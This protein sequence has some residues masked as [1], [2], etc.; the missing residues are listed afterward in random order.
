MAAGCARRGGDD[1]SR[2]LRLALKTAP[3]NLDPALVVDAAG[4]EICAQLFQGLVRYTPDGV[5]TG[6]AASA[7]HVEDD[8]RRYVF[9]LD[10]AARFSDG[11]RVTARDVVASFERVLAPGSA[12]SRRWVLDRIAGAGDFAAGNNDHIAG[13][14]A[15]DDSTVVLELT[16]PFA[17]FL[18][19]LALPA[20]MIVEAAAGAAGSDVTTPAPVGSGPWMVGEFRRGDVIALVPNPHSPRASRTL[21]RVR[22]RVIPEAFTQIAEFESGA[23]DVLDIPSAELRRFLDDAHYRGHI[24]SRPELRVYYI[25]LN[26]QRA[27]FSDVRV[28]RALNMAVDVDRLIEVLAAG[29]AVHAAGA[30]PPTLPGYAERDAYP[31]D[32]V[33]ARRLLAE[34]GYPEGF[35]MEIWQRESPEGNRILEAVQ[36]YLAE[37]GVSARLTRREWSAFKEAVSSGKV[38]AFLLDW[39]GDYP[40]AENF[41][42]PLFHSDNVGGGGNRAFFRDDAV[43]SLI[44]RASRTLD[45]AARARLYARADSLVYDQAPWI[46]LYFPKIFQA[47]SPR[48]E[49]YRTPTLYLGRD[50]TGVRKT[51]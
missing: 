36:G 30:I 41:L 12:S 5:L 23:L 42:Y 8:G 1:D 40:D 34:A 35:T 11:R 49:G 19:M 6:A 50:F 27:P 7:W 26:N 14:Q 4:G 15:P 2:V 46:Y 45:D 28:R 31:Y 18:S 25:G 37:V 43:D 20:A 9:S 16:A 44:E 21:D 29:E 48:V 47:V 33:Q 32:P 17:P 51:N 22:Y 13:A 10:P 38:D 24:Q 3:D 39:F